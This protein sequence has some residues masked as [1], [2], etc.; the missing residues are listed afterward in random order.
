[1]NQIDKKLASLEKRIDMDLLVRTIPGMLL[2][3]LLWPVVFLPSGYHQTE[4][5]LC[6][7]AAG[8]LL[9]LS[10]LRYLH[11]VTSDSF[12]QRSACN[13]LFVF[14][15]LIFLQAV[16]WGALFAL[17]LVKV[18]MEPLRLSLVLVVSGICSAIMTT[19]NPR[20]WIANIAI[21]ALLVP[22]IIAGFVV[23]QSI[24]I[25]VL[26]F[27]YLLYLLLLGKKT[28]QEYIR[29]FKIEFQLESQRQDLEQL[30]KIDP[31][32][33]IYNRG[34]FNTAFEFQWNAAIRSGEQQSLLLIDIDYF[35]KINDNYGHLIGD[36][37]LAHIANTI[38]KTVRRRTDLIAR[39]GGEEFVVLLSD[40]SLKKAC[41]I[42]ES[43][44]SSVESE[45]FI[46]QKVE[47]DISVSIGVACLYPHLSTNPKDL[48]DLADKALYR[49]K[50]DGRNCVRFKS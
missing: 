1:M 11:K 32:T 29:A 33:H 9:G 26:L 14:A 45:R 19:L 48:I 50:A 47:L 8:A 43:I 15:I 5:L 3:P 24:S 10:L 12:Y 30:N 7:G 36:E 23:L 13:W 44:R 49:A 42:A 37:C 35:K 27:L 46:F 25:T 17:A 18:E 6:W 2:Y 34:H 28:H 21:C 39:F 22:G 38:H 20:L 40:T 16:I 4:P 31:L 41:L